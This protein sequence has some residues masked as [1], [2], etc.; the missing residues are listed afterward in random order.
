MTDIKLR[1]IYRV[2]G[3][4]LDGTEIEPFMM[5]ILVRY[6][7]RK[8][9]DLYIPPIKTDTKEIKTWHCCQDNCKQPD[10]EGDITKLIEHLDLHK[11]R[12]VKH[13]NK[14]H[15]LKAPIPLVKLPGNPWEADDKRGA[16]PDRHFVVELYMS[17]VQRLLK[18]QGLETELANKSEQR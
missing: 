4:I 16:N 11:G 12:L 2:E 18:A 3:G 1:Q 13:W 6:P 7:H 8:S 10:F 9:P 5:T 15:Q 17:S 14:K